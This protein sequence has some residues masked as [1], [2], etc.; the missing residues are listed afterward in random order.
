MFPNLRAEMA[1][2]NITSREVSKKLD[3]GVKSMSNKLIGKTEFKRKEMFTI[4]H[5][6]FPEM[7]I[8]YLFEEGGSHDI[9]GD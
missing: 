6:Y 3:I 7:P 1:R 9:T 2:K 5:E 4:K 8:D